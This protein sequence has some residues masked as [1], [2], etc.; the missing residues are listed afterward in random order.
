MCHS[1][2]IQTASVWWLHISEYICTYLYVSI[3]IS[4]TLIQD[5]Y[6]LLAWVCLS[7]LTLCMQEAGHSLGT[8]GPLTKFKRQMSLTTKGCI[9]PSGMEEQ[10]RSVPVML[11]LQSAVLVGLIGMHKTG[12][13]GETRLV[14]H[15]PSSSWAGRRYYCY[16]C[17]Y[18]YCYH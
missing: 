6:A 2:S 11:P 17:Y 14:L 5:M 10:L 3:L 12:C 1:A 16:Y 13:S 9:T 4:C 18:H 7:L 8:G 15:V